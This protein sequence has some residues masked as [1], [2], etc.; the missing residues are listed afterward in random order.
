MDEPGADGAPPLQPHPNPVRQIHTWC[1]RAKAEAPEFEVV[2]VACPDD[3]LIPET[4]GFICNLKV[5]GTLDEDT[6]ERIEDL[7]V[8][9]EGASYGEAKA[10]A[11]T[12]AAELLSRTALWRS[13]MVDLEPAPSLWGT[14]ALALSDQGLHKDLELRTF[15]LLSQQSQPASSSTPEAARATLPV[16]LLT[17]AKLVGRWFRTHCQA[18]AGDPHLMLGELIKRRAE[19]AEGSDD[20]LLE[21]GLVLVEGGLCVQRLAAYFPPSEQYTV[22]TEVWDPNP[23]AV[24]IPADPCL[25]VEELPLDP[26]A[27]DILGQMARL[28]GAPSVGRLVLWGRVGCKASWLAGSER[29][30]A[31][32]A[33]GRTA[34]RI[35][36]GSPVCTVGGRP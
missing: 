3:P 2:R 32:A 11:A 9:G 16:T 34:A 14:V 33:G 8:Q 27:G 20:A 31:A 10:A 23:V 18:A 36:D 26:G 30:A 5:P 29:E 28:L 25:E 6:G 22:E 1:K 4:P 7:E 17:H 19:E 15:T 12:V 35:V 21:A 13:R 24:K